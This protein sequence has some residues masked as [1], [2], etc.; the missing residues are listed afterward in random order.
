MMSATKN[1]QN[2][3]KA[4]TAS[5]TEAKP[6][7]TGA[8]ATEKTITVTEEPPSAENKGD[9]A[10]HFTR[11]KLTPRTPPQQKTLPEGTGVPVC[12]PKRAMT[13]FD[14]DEGETSDSEEAN[15]AS[16]PATMPAIP[17]GLVETL[18]TAME[19]LKQMRTSGQNAAIRAEVLR[20][21]GEAIQQAGKPN[22]HDT[23]APRQAEADRN[24]DMANDIKEIKAAVKEIIA[25]KPKTW[26]L[27]AAGPGAAGMS[28]NTGEAPGWKQRQEKLRRERAKTEGPVKT[29]N[30]SEETKV[31]LNGMNESQITKSMR[32]VMIQAKKDSN[33]IE[34]VHKTPNQGLRIRCPTEQAAE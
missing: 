27:V 8:K 12:N 10:C 33:Y 13:P 28:L 16:G 11:S 19:T 31:G 22:E 15:S 29:Q 34:V 4:T 18:N 21:L 17:K 24:T 26:A 14:T 25:A 23:Q 9:D 6:P 7:R 20:M 3:T 1:N 30:A 2:P 32:D 5:P